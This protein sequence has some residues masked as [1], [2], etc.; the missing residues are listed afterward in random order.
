MVFSSLTFICIFLPAVILG[1]RILPSIKAKNALLLIASI[2]FYAYG[3]PVY[4]LL[5]IG[6][7][8]CNYLWAILME[9]FPERRKAVLAIGVIQNLG[10][11][12]IFKYAGFLAESFNSI[13][14]LGIPVPQIALPIGIS[15]FTFQAMSYMIDVYRGDCSVQK[16]FGRLLLYISFFPQLIAGPIVKYHD[17]E[18]ELLNRKQSI[19]GMAR[20]MRRFIC[21]LG[22]K[23]LIAN[24]LGAMVDGLFA[25]GTGDLNIITAW[26][27]TAGFFLQLYFDFSGYSDMA[28]GL[29]WTFG[30][31][32]RENI[33]YP[34]IAGSIKDYWARWHISL[35]SWFREYLYFPLG[36]NRKGKARTVINK[37][38]VFTL[39]GIW[40][41]ANVTFLLWGI[42]HGLFLMLEEIF[43][44][45]RKEGGPLKKVLVHI[46]TLIVVFVSMAI[47]RA[48]DIG[49]AF[50]WIGNMFAGM[51]FSPA[52]MRLVMAQLTPLNIV[53]FI[54]GC[55]A[56]TP[57]IKPL[58]GRAWAEKASYIITPAM[59]LLALVFLAGGTYNPFIY[60]RF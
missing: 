24:T 16:N 25:A 54:I 28:I 20:G 56:A 58:A 13:T 17:I 52:A 42:Y 40:H 12:C 41:G 22:K 36:G 14:G 43:P 21:G 57:L 31:H 34:I 30:F 18:E 10:V 37:F 6:N 1:C 35:T 60:F 5:M 59:L 27:G 48:D 44:G 11:L 15:F 32:F 55:F 39:S 38:I 9:K 4:V 33:N 51:N 46:Y 29:G 53:T 19:E 26:I 3:E 50:I 7:A 45:I 8:L 47:F 2:L 23:V 49:T